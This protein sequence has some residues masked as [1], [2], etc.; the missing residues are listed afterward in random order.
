MRGDGEHNW[1][2]RAGG[3]GKR[4]L[5]GAEKR[6]GGRLAGSRRAPSTS[7]GILVP[8]RHPVVQGRQ[9]RAGRPPADPPQTQTVTDRTW[10]HRRGYWR[11]SAVHKTNIDGGGVAAGPRRVTT[12]RND[13][14]RSAARR[15]PTP[16]RCAAACG[17][18]KKGRQH[19]QCAARSAQ[20]ARGGGDGKEGGRG[21]RLGC[22][23]EGRGGGWGWG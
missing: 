13:A 9:Y 8:N 5:G 22:G 1:G 16:R 11:W 3:G 23:G 2:C 15:S 6:S 18:R 21:R 17:V 12:A 7:S 10:K 19:S 14:P 20:R 4:K